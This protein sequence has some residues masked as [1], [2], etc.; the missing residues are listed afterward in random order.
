MPLSVQ[1]IA[2]E[3]RA[4]TPFDWQRLQDACRDDDFKALADLAGLPDYFDD[5][6]DGPNE[7]ELEQKVELAEGRIATLEAQVRALSGAD[8]AIGVVGATITLRSGKVFDY[9]SPTPE[10]VDIEDIAWA[11][12]KE[13][14]YANQLPGSLV[15]SVGQHSCM[16]ADHAPDEWKL[17]ALLHDAPEYVTKDIPKPLKMLIGPGYAAVEDRVWLTIAEK[18]G[19]PTK[20][21]PI[22]KE[23]DWQALNT[24][25]KF[26]SPDRRHDWNGLNDYPPFEDI[27]PSNLC[28]WTIEHCAAQFLERFRRFSKL[29]RAAA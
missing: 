15:W 13:G 17:V 20:L 7:A 27:K 4:F 19:L 29:E 24:E 8:K 21:P 9:L 3:L 18:F 26:L 12:A 6:H 25:K 1:Q 28:P 22:V 11:L 10:M 2:D 16:V 5:D 23:L 14:R